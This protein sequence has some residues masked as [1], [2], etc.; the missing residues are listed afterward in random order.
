MYWQC[1]CY[2]F[3]SPCSFLDLSTP[4]WMAKRPGPMIYRKGA[5]ET[6]E[7]GSSCCYFGV[8]TG[9]DVSFAEERRS[10]GHSC[11]YIQVNSCWFRHW[12]HAKKRAFSHSSRWL[13]AVS[14]VGKSGMQYLWRNLGMSFPK[15]SLHTKAEL[16]HLLLL[17]RLLQSKITNKHL[18]AAQVLTRIRIQCW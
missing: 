10:F 7:K 3:L 2:H 12:L 17:L 13:L 15:P 8:G 9:W 18:S 4:G 14:I 5:S 16:S 6:R 1:W 11:K